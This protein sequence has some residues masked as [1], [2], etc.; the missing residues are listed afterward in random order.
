MTRTQRCR[1]Q[2]EA[3]GGTGCEVLDEN[4]GARQRALQQRQILALLDVEGD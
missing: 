1:T 2:A 4:A 3:P